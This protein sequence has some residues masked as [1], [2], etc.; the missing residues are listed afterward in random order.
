MDNR[1][2][3]RP[4]SEASATELVSQLREARHRTRC[5]TE[6]LSSGELMGPRL[7][8]VNPALWEI[9][10]VGW[11]HEYWTLRHAAGQ[12]PLIARGDSLWDSSAVPHATRWQ[13]DLPDRAGT[14][15]YL[16]EVL[17]R[18]E[19]LLGRGVDDDAR[20]FYELALRHEDM[21]VEA[22]T[23]TRQTL[24][25]D[26]PDG[27]GTGGQPPAGAG[28]LDG[29]A[30]I[31][32]GAWRLGSTSGD[33]FIFDN[34]KWA[35]ETVLAPFRI[36]RAPVTNAQFAAFIAED[37]Y[38]AREFWSDA[39]WAWRERR[40]AERPV[41]WD[42]PRD[43][44]LTARRYRASAPLAPDAPVIFVSWFEAEAWCRWAGRRLPTEAEWEA[45]AVGVPDASGARL[46]DSRRRWP[47]GDAP[48]APSR[49]NLDFA[50]DG[51]V[52]VAALAAGDSAFGCRQMI[53]NV[54]EWTASDFLPFAGFEA[55][56]YKDYSQPWFGTRKVLRGGAW[57]T[58]ARIARPAYRN[59]FTPDRNDVLAGFRTCAL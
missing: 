7:D 8:I 50:S 44:T 39:G 47:W 23:Y 22:L 28:G 15:A 58:S 52:D 45:A 1:Q 55:D 54:W 6:D 3:H 5:L 9:G 18:Q 13:L 53:G 4:T 37:G 40:R 31:P 35:H 41:Y 59:F 11:F 21:H 19:A 49:A 14:F 2:A 51:P 26:P 33:G 36:A 29:D 34:E 57:A 48:P 24:A 30:A 25:F 12:A 16:A 32:G 56:P 43:G 17:A 46:A 38:R 27:L 42:P 10:H 20:Y